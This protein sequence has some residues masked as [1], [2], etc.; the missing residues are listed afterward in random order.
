MGDKDRRREGKVK[1]WAYAKL[2]MTSVFISVASKSKTPL[3]R[4]TG[5]V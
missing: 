4:D 2:G 5:P 1:L 3:P